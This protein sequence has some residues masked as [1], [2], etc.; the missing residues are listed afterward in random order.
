MSSDAKARRPVSED[1]MLKTRHLEYIWK[2]VSQ[3]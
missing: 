3:Y 1:I 2:Q